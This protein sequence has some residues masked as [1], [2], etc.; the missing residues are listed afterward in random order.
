[1]P[2]SFYETFLLLNMPENAA[3]V[4]AAFLIVCGSAPAMRLVLCSGYQ[5]Q[6]ALFSLNGKAVSDRKAPF[7]KMELLN[8]I[9]KD[10]MKTA[11]KSAFSPNPPN[12]RF[13]TE[14]HLRRLHFLGWGYD[15]IG[16]FCGAVSAGVLPLGI[17]L[18]VVFDEF[19]LA[20]AL[21]AAAMF[22]LIRLFDSLFDYTL[23]KEKLTD[24]LSEYVGREIGQFYVR[25]KAEKPTET[26]VVKMA[27]SINAALTGPVEMWRASLAEASKAQDKLTETCA[28]LDKALGEAHAVTVQAAENNTLSAQLTYIEQNQTLLEN[29]LLK[30]E[31]SIES[32]AQNMGES[33]GHIAQFHAKNALETSNNALEANVQ[34]IITSNSDTLRQ[35]QTLFENMQETRKRETQALI[36]LN[37][38]IT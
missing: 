10:Y 20:F 5:T 35:M 21:A 29:S 36:N 7:S 2:Q 23:A 11:D 9:I 12:A 32:M 30:Y 19:R 18:A 26:P 17:L 13:F 31:Q 34:A 14:K 37:E 24:A 1:M 38:R 25:P 8:R 27:E 33:I 4:L 28:T 3:A 6:L 15:S 16:R 22:A